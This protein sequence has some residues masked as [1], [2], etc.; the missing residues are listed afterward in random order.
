MMKQHK[1]IL[2]VAVLMTVTAFVSLSAQDFPSKWLFGKAYM[3]EQEMKLWE[4]DAK[5]KATVSGEGV[6]TAVDAQGNPKNGCR[7]V[8]GRP[9]VPVTAGDC[10]VFEIPAVAAGSFV[11]F[12]ATLSANPGAP[13]NWVVEWYDGG[14]WVESRRYRVH[15]PALGNDHRYTSIYQ[16]F[17]LADPAE[18]DPVKV[19]LRALEGACIPAEDGKDSDAY[20][21]LVTSTYIGAYVRNLGTAQPEDTTR[22]LCIGNSF[23]YYHSCPLMLKE[24]AWSEGHYLDMSA[25]LKGGRTMKHHQSLAMTEDLVADGG[26][27]VV[28]LQDQSQAAAKVGRD[29]KEHASL[30]EEMEA[31]AEKVIENSPGCLPIIECTWAYPGKEHG[32]FGTLKAFDAYAEKGARIMS[33]AVDGSVIS[34]INK[35]FKLAREEHPDIMLYHTD[36]HHQSEYGSYLKSCVNYLVLFGEPFGDSPADCG[37]DKKKTAVLRSIAEKCVYIKNNSRK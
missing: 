5:I 3:G 17:R 25:S 34:P 22:V 12:D 1:S 37:L 31:M 10:F 29:R 36:G 33:K 27:D 20:A 6:M 2:A 4:N 9:A 21:M 28:F 23:T 13:M 14:K 35:A 8:K 7:I 16:T 11:D 15:G 30:V 19:R 18:G 32:G 24:I 26:Y